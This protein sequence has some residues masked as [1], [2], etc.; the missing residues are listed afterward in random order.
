MP[1]SRT[2][3]PFADP[4]Y[5]RLAVT[6][7]TGGVD[8]RRTPTQLDSDRARALTNW[9]ITQPGELMVRPGYLQY[10]TAS[11]GNLRAQGGE[12]VYLSSHT[13]TLA[14]YDGAV[15]LVNDTGWSSVVYSTVS[16]ASQVYFPHD[17]DM[18]AVFDSTNAIV[19]STNGSSWTTFGIARPGVPSTVSS[20]GSGDFQATKEYG[21]NFT[22]QS[23]FPHESNGSTAETTLTMGST[24]SVSVSFPGSTDVQVTSVN[25]YA[26][27]ITDGETVRR[28]ISSVAN[29]STLSV[30][31]SSTDWSRN[32]EEP[33]DHNVPEVMAFAVVWKNRWWGRDA[34]V[35]NRLRFTQVFQAQSWPATFFIDIPFQDGDGIEALEVLGDSLLAFGAT[36]IYVIFGQTSLDFEVRPA[37][38]ASDGALGPRAVDV[39][40]NGVVHAAASGVY[41]FDGVSDRLLSYDI[42]P[43][44][45]DLV[46]NATSADVAKVAIEYDDRR[47][48]LRIAVPRVYPSG[49]P[50][51]WILDLN[52]TRLQETPAWASS[53]RRIGGYIHWHGPESDIGN[54]GRL[55]TWSDTTGTIFTESTGTTANSS[56]MVAEYEGPTFASNPHRVRTIDTDG[57]YEPNDG[58]FSIETTVD[59]LSKGNV[60][61][62]IGAGI[63]KYG[64]AV[65]GTGTYGGSGRKR[66]FRMLPLHAEGRTFKRTMRYVGT[67]GFRIY[68]Y[69]YGIV[70]EV[71]PLEFSD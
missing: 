68:T 63:A 20:G 45:R 25:V 44:W 36:D 55:Q 53:D 4:A 27:N 46:E 3:Q 65:Y 2:T 54:R 9:S 48:E 35:K 37:I 57:E 70:P 40:E 7:M 43:A 14:A 6:D 62:N 64:T 33:T 42:E 15:R 11:L 17:R 29:A 5:Q 10:T 12:R 41:I 51:E 24:G 47:K 60:T 1:R 56:N 31:L 23:D 38:D 19:K 49:A 28:K 16:T 26:R 66:Y 50:G 32:A 18:V 22:F 71:A 59:E 61:I 69:G 58:T 13:F 52:R 67:A 34:T 30:T 8:L 39:I 21:F